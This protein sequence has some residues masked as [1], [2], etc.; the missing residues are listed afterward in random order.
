MQLLGEAQGG[1]PG[2]QCRHPSHNLLGFYRPVWPAE[3]VASRAGPERPVPEL[4]LGLLPASR[5]ACG[6]SVT[7]AVRK[8]GDSTFLALQG[9]ERTSKN[10]SRLQPTPQHH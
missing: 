6:V 4:T 7:A 8:G 1:Q 2:R 5:A 3:S 9:T 10:P